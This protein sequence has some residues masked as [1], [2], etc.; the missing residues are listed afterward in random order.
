MVYMNDD[1][2]NGICTIGIIFGLFICIFIINNVSDVND[3]YGTMVVLNGNF[4][5]FTSPPLIFIP[6]YNKTYSSS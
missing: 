4:I 1:N 3:E 6:E 5:L 2:I